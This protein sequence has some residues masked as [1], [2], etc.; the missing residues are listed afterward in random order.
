MNRGRQSPVGD[1]AG[2]RIGRRLTAA[3]V[4][5]AA[6]A[7]VLWCVSRLGDDARRGVSAHDRYRVRFADIQCNP[8]P[9]TDRSTFLAEVRYLASAP[10]TVQSLD[11]TLADTLTAAF[12]RHPWVA[13]VESVIIERD[14]AVHVSLRHRKPR[15]VLQTADGVRVVDE[16]GVVLPIAA[17]ARGLPEW[18]T[19]APS[20]LPDAGRSWPDEDVKRALELAEAH[21]SLT[22]EKGPAGWRLT[23]ADGKVLMVK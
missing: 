14:G 23:M 13:A 18:I 17:E 2:R 4:T 20:P 8:P 3:A 21:H 12:S 22:L 10:E 19:K 16:T 15:L 5:L 1:R 7:A 11:P 9:G 6:A